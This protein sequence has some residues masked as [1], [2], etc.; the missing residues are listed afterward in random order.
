[1][2]LSDFHLN[3]SIVCFHSARTLDSRFTK[4]AQKPTFATALNASCYFNDMTSEYGKLSGKKI[5]KHGK[6]SVHYSLDSSI[7]IRIF[8]SIFHYVWDNENKIWFPH[9]LCEW[10]HFN[11]ITNVIPLSNLCG[12]KARH[13]HCSTTTTS[14]STTCTSTAPPLHHDTI[15]S[16]NNIPWLSPYTKEG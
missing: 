16:N 9:Y 10:I 15:S 8:L 12:T 4:L 2:F 3:F 13:N 14:T 6:E 5:M 7:N 1:M 11:G